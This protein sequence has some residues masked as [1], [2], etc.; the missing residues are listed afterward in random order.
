MPPTNQ[1]PE[2]RQSLILRLR[3][4]DDVSAWE[5]FIE[6]Y[7]SLI[8]S[9]AIRRGLQKADADD[10]AQEVLAS[11]ASHIDTWNQDNNKS[12]FRAWLATITRNETFLF[13]RKHAR[14]PVTGAKFQI[15]QMQ[16]ELQEIDFDLEHDR[17]LFA[18]A[19]RR[20]QSRFEPKTWQ[21]FWQTAVEER[22][23]ADVAN[24][25]KTTAAQVY[26]ARSRVM[27]ALKNAVEGSEFESQVDWRVS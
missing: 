14:R 16:I 19:S 1:S 7:Q 8:Y 3:N 24:E 22:P 2:T 11:V 6:V 26:V 18:W 21:A 5:E 13:F 9:L 23:V 4:P 15:D 27:S 25:L 12:S 20:V 17:Q 10:V